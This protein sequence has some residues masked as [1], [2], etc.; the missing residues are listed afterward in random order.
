[1]SEGPDRARPVPGPDTP[2]P[3][4]PPYAPATKTATQPRA[5]QGPSHGRGGVW[6]G[7]ILVLVGVALLVQ[8]FFP[9][10][11]L[12]EFWPVIIIVAG[13]LMIVRSGRGGAR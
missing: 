2:P 6:L 7:A 13:V 11:R 4:P 12:W 9:A 3:P 1:M 5:G 8:L 10:I